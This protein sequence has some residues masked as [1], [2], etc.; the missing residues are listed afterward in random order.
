MIKELGLYASSVSR[1]LRWRTENSEELPDG[2][3]DKSI[4]SKAINL[5]LKGA[6]EEPSGTDSPSKAGSRRWDPQKHPDLKKYLMDVIDSLLNHLADSSENKIFTRTPDKGM[7][8]W[9]AG[10]KPRTADTEWLARTSR[11]PEELLLQ[12]ERAELEDHALDM[13]EEEVADD[14]VLSKVIRAMRDSEGPAQVSDIAKA[15]GIPIKD[16]Y[17]ANKRLDRK[18]EE[19]FKKIG[20]MRTESTKRRARR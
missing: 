18:A 4:V 7:G 5:V 15:T 13:L 12:K 10:L 20:G 16:V 17:N 11:S 3:T 6:L 19:V 1:P 14:K 8:K 9:E 2:E